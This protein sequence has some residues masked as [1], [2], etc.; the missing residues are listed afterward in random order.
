MKTALENKKRILKDTI[1]FKTLMGWSFIK[2]AKTAIIHYYN[3]PCWLTSHML[4]ESNIANDGSYYFP[5][6][7]EISESG[8]S[9]KIIHDGKFIYVPISKTVNDGTIYFIPKS[10]I[11]NASDWTEM[12]LGSIYVGS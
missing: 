7:Y 1:K 6:T 3:D 11:K 12:N 2:S 4:Q 8:K 9:L 5:D 10:V